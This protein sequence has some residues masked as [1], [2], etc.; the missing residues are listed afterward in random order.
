ML[1]F[2]SIFY[3]IFYNRSYGLTIAITYSVYILLDKSPMNGGWN[4]APKW[5]KFF[6]DYPGFKLMAK[7]FDSQLI[8]ETDL[9]PRQ[10]YIFLYHP[11]GIISLGFCTVL[12]TNGAN[13]EDTF[14]GV[15][16]MNL[17]ISSRVSV[18]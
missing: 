5:R 11:H 8:K 14:P 7:Y 1:Y 13:F 4:L 15:S 16:F 6:R 18:I 10:Q 2:G 17:P 3:F 12:A 9:D